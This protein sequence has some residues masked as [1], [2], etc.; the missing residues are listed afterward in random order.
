LYKKK[1]DKGGSSASGSPATVSARP[2]QE[3]LWDRPSGTDPCG[4]FP[5]ARKLITRAVTGL[6][7]PG[8]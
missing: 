3:V 4:A 6:T 1:A 7:G 2:P 8:Y 5:T